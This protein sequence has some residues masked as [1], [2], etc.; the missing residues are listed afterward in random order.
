MIINICFLMFDNACVL[1][2]SIL[3]QTQE[4]KSL[5]QTDQWL[6]PTFRFDALAGN[7]FPQDLQDQEETRQEDE[8]EQ[9]H[10]LLDPHENRQYHQEQ[11][12]MATWWVD[13]SHLRPIKK[14]GQA[15][16]DLLE[17]RDKK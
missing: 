5:G 1:Y 10:P 6:A 3:V 15:L 4:H 8:A 7:S 16:F 14:V 12:G 2:P 17:D 9:A 11:V 13:Y